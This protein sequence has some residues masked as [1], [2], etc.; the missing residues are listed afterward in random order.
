MKTSSQKSSEPDK[1]KKSQIE[2]LGPGRKEKDL[3]PVE[4]KKKRTWVIVVACLTICLTF[5]LVV[6]LSALAPVVRPSTFPVGT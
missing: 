6:G 1:S 2:F 3:E 4:K 5:Q